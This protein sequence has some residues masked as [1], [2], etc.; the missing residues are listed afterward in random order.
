MQSPVNVVVGEYYQVPCIR[1]WPS[2]KIVPVLLPAHTDETE[3][4]L[5]AAPPHYHIDFRFTHPSCHPFNAYWQ[6]DLEPFYQEMKAIDHY[7]QSFEVVGES[8]FFFWNRWYRRYADK[9]LVNGRCPHKGVQVVNACG[10]CPAHGLLWNMTSGGL[11]EFKLPF[12]LEVANKQ[13]PHPDN[14][15][16]QVFDEGCK[17]EFSKP[18]DSDGSVIMVDSDGKRFGK[19]WQKIAP[20]Y[21]RP[22]DMLRINTQD[23]CK[24]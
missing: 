15:R 23:L 8:A 21:Y 11:V 19:T 18:Y 20:R 3:F 9:K 7:V 12:F 1:S 16:G 22:G 2:Q 6:Y 5:Q 24:L 17:I 10:T 4:C 14:V 13:K